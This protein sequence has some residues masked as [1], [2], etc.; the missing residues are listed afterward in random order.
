[1]QRLRTSMKMLAGRLNERHL[2]FTLMLSG[3]LWRLG[4]ELT[5]SLGFCGGHATSK[6]PTVLS[7]QLPSMPGHCWHWPNSVW[8]LRT[9]FFVASHGLFFL[10]LL[11]SIA[12]T[13]NTKWPVGYIL[14]FCSGRS[15]QVFYIGNP[16]PKLLILIDYRQP[17]KPLLTL[18][19]ATAYSE[20]LS[21]GCAPMIIPSTRIVITTTTR[22][23]CMLN[24]QVDVGHYIVVRTSALPV[25]A[26]VVYW[27]H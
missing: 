16:N 6:G 13:I 17:R 11:Q 25:V 9:G 24:V 14:L 2:L 22:I 26:C 19:G 27:V 21:I 7:W 18:L 1:M 8:L 15:S 5:L 12:A 3:H 4:L 20:A 10:S 23:F